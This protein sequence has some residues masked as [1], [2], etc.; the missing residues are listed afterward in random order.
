MYECTIKSILTIID[1][2]AWHYHAGALIGDNTSVI[3][4]SERLCYSSRH[5][6]AKL[7]ELI[8]NQIK[9]LQQSKSQ[10]NLDYDND[11]SNHL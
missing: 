6:E 1:D 2:D 7:Q 3:S 11:E 9:L 5:I 8:Q 4:T 10:D